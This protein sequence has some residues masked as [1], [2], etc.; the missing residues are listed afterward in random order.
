MGVVGYLKAVRWVFAPLLMAVLFAQPAAA[1]KPADAPWP[2]VDRSWSSG[3]Y[4]SLIENVKSGRLPLPLLTDPA[5][6]PVFERIVSDDNVANILP[7]NKQLPAT[8]RLREVMGSLDAVG[9]LL[10]LYLDETK[11]GKPHERELAKLMVQMISLAGSSIVLA[12]EG[13]ATMPRDSGFATREYGL[14][15]MR[16]GAR[17]IFAGVIQSITE[18][19][20]FSK[21]SMLEMARGVV[22]NLPSLR[23]TL[24]DA[25]RQEHQRRIGQLI[26]DAKDTEIKAALVQMHEA[27]G[28]PN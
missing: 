23:S 20:F 17:Q 21:A 8:V 1:Q 26:N 24:T 12:D 15:T 16:Q 11:K 6:K 27:L 10:A 22:T 3:D 4:R 2:P 18:T 28:K 25:E 5:S 9:L 14:Q 19:H 7:W 13:M